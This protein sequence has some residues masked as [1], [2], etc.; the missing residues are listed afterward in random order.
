VVSIVHSVRIGAAALPFLVACGGG[1]NANRPV[2]ALRA[3]PAAF[4]PG[5][6]VTLR[7]V[8]D[9]GSGRIEPGVGAV[10]SGGTYVVGPVVADTVYTLFVDRPGGTETAVLQVPIRYRERVLEL[11]P[12][13]IARTRHGAVALPDGSVLV[14]GGVLADGQATDSVEVWSPVTRSWRAWAARLPQPR[15]GH[16]LQVLPNGRVV[17]LGG[18]PGD[19]FPVPTCWRID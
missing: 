15:T 11:P 7:P 8:F 18:D 10:Q 6:T 4:A 14:A 2:P 16:S 12:S 13:A 17:L 9:G 3:E 19:G 5:G 1:R